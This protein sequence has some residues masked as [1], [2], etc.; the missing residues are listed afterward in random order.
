MPSNRKRNQQESKG[1]TKQFFTIFDKSL[2]TDT[3]KRDTYTR[4]KLI[5][6]RQ[7][8]SGDFPRYLQGNNPL[9]RKVT[10]LRKIDVFSAS[11][12]VSLHPLLAADNS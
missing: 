10:N 5:L 8:L 2:N 9:D 12:E 6:S 1:N 3:K 11:R 4:E 7:K